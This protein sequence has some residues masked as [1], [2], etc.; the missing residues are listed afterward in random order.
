MSE[1]AKVQLTER[2]EKIVRA[3]LREGVT[4]ERTRI[5]G[6]LADQGKTVSVSKLIKLIKDE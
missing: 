4:L 3:I 1:K 6:I 5:L 2:Q